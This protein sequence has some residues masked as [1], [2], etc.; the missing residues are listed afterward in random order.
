VWGAPE[1]CLPQR[2]GYSYNYFLTGDGGQTGCWWS[3]SS[4]MVRPR[5]W[6]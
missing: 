6:S 3:W 2:Q 5:T 4:W 1:N